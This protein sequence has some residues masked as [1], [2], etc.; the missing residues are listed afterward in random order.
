MGPMTL[1]TAR[2]LMADATAAL[3]DAHEAA[4]EGQNPRASREALTAHAARLVDHAIRAAAIGEAALV[5]L[6]KTR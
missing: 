4:I 2:R 6:E 5:A 1:D 3:E